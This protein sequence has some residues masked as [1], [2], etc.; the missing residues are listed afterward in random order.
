METEDVTEI[1]L[2]AAAHILGVSWATAWKLV[3]TGDLVGRKAGGRWLVTKQ[4]IEG[5]RARRST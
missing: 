1:G 5:Y 3:L 4:S 2:A